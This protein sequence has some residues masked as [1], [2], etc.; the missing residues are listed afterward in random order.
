MLNILSNSPKDEVGTLLRTFGYQVLGKNQKESIL[1][2]VDGKEHLGTLVAEY[3][4]K[5]H[6]RSYV[7]VVERGEGEFD[8]TQPGLRRQLIEYDRA[9]GLNGVLLVDAQK[10]VIHK[11]DFGF[12]R[13]RNIDF[14][15]QFLIALFIVFGVIGIIWLM[16]MVKLF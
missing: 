4:V 8:P 15:F 9:F 13:E 16:V 3:T 12:P 11:V 2:R 5:K 10:K 6:N 7:V 1:I 14:Y